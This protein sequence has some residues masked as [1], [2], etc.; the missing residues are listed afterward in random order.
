MARNPLFDRRH[1][2]ALA[3]AA[4]L[5]CG[6]WLLPMAARAQALGF[7]EAL[8]ADDAGLGHFPD[9]APTRVASLPDDWAQS[10]PQ[11]SSPLWYRLRFDALGT[12]ANTGPLALYIERACANVE[13]QLN[14]QAL[15]AEGRMSD[16]ISLDCEQIGRAHV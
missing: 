11:Q 14:G 1:T 15:H 9:D 12:A 4:C 2:L 8:V 16:P 6:L 7:M 3:L 5:C 10:R 13:V